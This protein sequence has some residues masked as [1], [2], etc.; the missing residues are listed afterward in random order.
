MPLRAKAPIGFALPADWSAQPP[1]IPLGDAAIGL[2]VCANS[3]TEFLYRFWV[4]NEIFFARNENRPLAPDIASR[5][6]RL[7]G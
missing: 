6:A 2:Q 7:P 5:A 1:V 3:F 4:E